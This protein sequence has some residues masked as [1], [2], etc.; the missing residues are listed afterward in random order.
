MKDYFQ[1]EEKG[2]DGGIGK[3]LTLILG[4]Q[5][6]NTKILSEIELASLLK[7]VLTTLE[8]EINETK[9]EVI[10]DFSRLNDI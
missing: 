4:I 10:S 9:T 3:D 5:K 6:M 1:E 7:K 8:P 2:R